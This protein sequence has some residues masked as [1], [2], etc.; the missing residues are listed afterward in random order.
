MILCSPTHEERGYGRTD[1]H[2]RFLHPGRIALLISTLKEPA[3]PVGQERV[4]GA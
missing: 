2:R 4:S 3:D 1:H